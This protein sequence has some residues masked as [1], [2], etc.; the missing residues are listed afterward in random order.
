MKKLLISLVFII[1]INITYSQS[2][3]FDNCFARNELNDDFTDEDIL[4]RNER[5]KNEIIGCKVPNFK[6]TTIKGDTI[7][8]K[9]LKGK[10]IVLNFWFIECKPCIA[11]IPGLNKL[12]DYY[13]ETDDI[14]FIS[15][16]R[17]D[18]KDIETYF[19]PKHNF[20]YKIIP[21]CSSISV[22]YCIIAGWPTHMIINKK[23]KLH[24][25]F[26]GGRVEGNVTNYIFDLLSTNIEECLNKK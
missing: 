23:G 13:S 17:N 8:I 12:V 5:F 24:N 3:C 1:N 19:L 4:N 2:E 22:D 25:V 10:I 16:C 7:E 21:S 26:Y 15:L 6:A 20:N 18:L 9:N 11:E 14:V